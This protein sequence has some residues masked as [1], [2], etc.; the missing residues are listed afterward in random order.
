MKVRVIALQ[1]QIS[2]HLTGSGLY[3]LFLYSYSVLWSGCGG[4]IHSQTGIV[5]SPNF[6]NTY[7]SRIEC[8][9]DINVRQG[10]HINITFNQTFGIEQSANCNNDFVQ[11]LAFSFLLKCYFFYFT[12]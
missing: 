7:R 10:Y 8:V 6:P 5:S 3:I 11:V 4:V 1:L 12:T 9:W 2:F